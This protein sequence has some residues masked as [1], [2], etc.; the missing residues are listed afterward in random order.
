MAIDIDLVDGKQK[1]RPDA[2]IEVEEGQTVK[3]TVS[4]DKAYEIHIHGYDKSIDVPAGGE[5]SVEFEADKTGT[6]EVEV[7]DTGFKLFDLR[8]T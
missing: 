8:V 7:E 1:E 2:V 6:W 3:L 5:E 4:S